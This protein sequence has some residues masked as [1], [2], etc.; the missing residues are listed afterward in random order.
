MPGFNPKIND[1]TNT[2]TVP[3]ANNIECLGRWDGEWY[4]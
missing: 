1:D 2:N 4:G 3:A